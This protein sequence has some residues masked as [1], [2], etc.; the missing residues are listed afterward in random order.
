MSR[1]YTRGAA[2]AREIPRGASVCLV[3]EPRAYRAAGRKILSALKG[4]RVSTFLLP[5]GEKAKTWEAVSQVLSHL[6]Q[7]GLRRDG[8]LV[9]VGGGAVTDAAG[10]AA[11]IYL[12]GIPWISVPTTALGQLDGGLGGKTAINLPEGKNLAGAFHEPVAVV[13]DAR[14]LASLPA[15]ERAAGLAEALKIGLVFEPALFR[16]IARNWGRLVRGDA[17]LLARVVAKAAGWKLRVVASDPRETKGRRELL[18]FGHTLGHALE[19]AAGHGAL[20][21][22][23]AVVWGLRAALR[24]S[25]ALAGLPLREADEAESFLESISVPLP[26]SSVDKIMAAAARDKKVRA[27]AWRFVLLRRLG[28]PVTLP[29]EPRLARAV[30]E[31]LL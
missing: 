3:S 28:R 8:W 24:L 9:A 11:A 26:R 18:N 2:W 15:R 16:L 22:G 5:S 1:L 27:G 6:L 17:A 30:A 25:V 23:E 14:L 4:R 12:R 31:G 20:R 21:H 13:C 7:S 19:N 29:V 10:F